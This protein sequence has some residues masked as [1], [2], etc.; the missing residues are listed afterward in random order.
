MIRY[1]LV[2]LSIFYSSNT[3]ASERVFNCK[4]DSFL[5]LQGEM[6]SG[7]SGDKY[8]D[9]SFE[10]VFTEDRVDFKLAPTLYNVAATP[11]NLIIGKNGI[12]FSAFR[13][14]LIV[15]FAMSDLIF[16]QTSIG[17]GVLFHAKC[18]LK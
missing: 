3:V 17:Q 4:T 1:L 5:A 9:F 16:A 11:K 15:E 12:S 7:Y 6:G 18:N 8:K 13:L 14:G 10:M 2:A